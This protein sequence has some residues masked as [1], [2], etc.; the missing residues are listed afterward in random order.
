L[1]KK[2]TIGILVALALV[3]NVTFF[4]LKPNQLAAMFALTLLGGFAMASLFTLLWSMFADVADY[5]EWRTGRRATG[6]VFSVS[7]MCTKIGGALSSAGAGWMLKWIGFQPNVAA[8][9][10][11]LHGLV[12]LMSLI[13][14]A[15]GIV[16]FTLVFFYPLSKKRL[17]EIESDLHV[18]RATMP[19]PVGGEN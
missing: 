12:L 9:P 8:T 5:S 19:A 14:A 10:K 2:L 16:S 1:G 3:S 7:L 11:V 17:A 4:F 15:I 13:P 18:R 6:L